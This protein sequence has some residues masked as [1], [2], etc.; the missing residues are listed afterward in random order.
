MVVGL[1]LYFRVNNYIQDVV[2]PLGISG[3]VI[4]ITR[5][6]PLHGSRLLD[7]F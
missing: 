6:R 1:W 5:F 4:G 2:D 7:D 3:S